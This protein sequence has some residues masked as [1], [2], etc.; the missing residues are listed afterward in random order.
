MQEDA[1]HFSSI[2]YMTSINY[3]LWILFKFALRFLT[4]CLSPST[5]FKRQR[6][7][8]HRH[9]IKLER[10]REDL[11]GPCARMTT[12]TNWEMMKRQWKA[13]DCK[14]MHQAFQRSP[15]FTFLMFSPWH[16]PNICTHDTSF[17][18]KLIIIFHQSLRPYF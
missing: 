17:S 1:N 15:C 12:C 18:I 5:N 4:S 7:S 9:M 10:Y 11:R 16:S 14:R 2:W 6:K 8:L 3:G 13:M